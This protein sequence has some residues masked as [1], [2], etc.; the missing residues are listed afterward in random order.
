MVQDAEYWVRTIEL[1]P[2]PEGG[3]FRET[4]RSPVTLELQALPAGYEGS[5]SVSTAIYFLLKKGQFSALHRLRSDE[6][7]HFHAGGPLKVVVIDECGTG[8]EVLLGSCPENGESFQAVVPAGCWFGALPVEGASYSLVSCTVAPGFDFRDFELGDRDDLLERY[9][10]HRKI[11]E[12]LT[13]AAATETN[14][15]KW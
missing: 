11:I 7:W 15:R 1:I 14:D 5:R 13:R 3:Y 9:P 6:L 10:E 12:Q 4:Y 8:K 2:H